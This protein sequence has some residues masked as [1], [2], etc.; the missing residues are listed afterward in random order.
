MWRNPDSARNLFAPP[1]IRQK[2]LT[3]ALTSH[4]SAVYQDV[5]CVV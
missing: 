3:E 1:G 4:A 5:R 2:M